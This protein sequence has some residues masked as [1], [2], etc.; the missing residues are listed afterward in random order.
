[1]LMD[2]YFKYALIS[3]KKPEKK[4]FLKLLKLYQK[5]SR[6]KCIPFNFFHYIFLTNVT[7]IFLR[8]QAKNY[9]FSYI[10]PIFIISWEDQDIQPKNLFFKWKFVVGVFSGGETDVHLTK[11]TWFISQNINSCLYVKILLN[12]LYLPFTVI[13]GKNIWY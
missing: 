10:G 8:W 9:T 12:L 2:I 5:P 13:I 1:M 7:I 4:S 11:N 3:K 6:I